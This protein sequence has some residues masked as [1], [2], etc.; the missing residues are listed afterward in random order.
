[1]KTLDKMTDKEP[2][3]VSVIIPTYNRPQF[4]FDA[5]QSILQQTYKNL[6]VIVVNDGGVD[7]GYI[8]KSLNDTRFI[9]LNQPE[10]K[11]P[12]AARNTALKQAQGV[13]ITY[14][15]DD[16]SF[17]PH[18]VATLV[19]ALRATHYKAA[20]TDICKVFK[21]MENGLLK[22]YKT[23][24]YAWNVSLSSLLVFNHLTIAVMH[25]RFCLNTAGQFDES[26]HRHEDWDLWI[27]VW[28]DSPFLHIPEVT[29]NYTIFDTAEHGQTQSSW[30]GHF[31]NTMQII[32][33]RYRNLVDSFPNSGEI[34]KKQE[35]KRQIHQYKALLQMEEMTNEQLEQLL[36]NNVIL[37]IAEGSL[38]NTKDDIR[39]A[40]A[41]T[42]YL[43]QRLPENI[44]AWLLHAKLCRILRDFKFAGIAITH[45]LQLR[46]TKD[47]LIECLAIAE[48]GGLKKE[49]EQLRT[50]IMYFRESNG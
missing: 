31:L 10:H 48:E 20:Y 22:V 41:L 47:A 35:A 19:D 3:L 37:Q 5:L 1:M 43:T 11:G 21:R 18:H 34:R 4:L 9:Y 23:E 2:L 32:H 25:E 44:S 50:H 49:A 7:V 38:L 36:S 30:I 15:D 6:E 17:Y 24:L 29:V 46:E 45:A 40:R 26:L 8:V 28:K 13:Y 16:D 42:G 33:A 14:L 12:S 39:A 27:R